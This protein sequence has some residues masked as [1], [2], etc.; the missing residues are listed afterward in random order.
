MFSDGDRQVV[1]TYYTQNYRNGCPPGLVR[2]GNDCLTRGMARRQYAV[3]RRLARNVVIAPV[4]A[5][6]FRQLSPVP[7]GYRYGL[8]D[9]DV[10][11]YD[12][13]TRLVV[14]AI[15]ALLD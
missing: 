8:V 3:G 5:P 7:S 11:R 2:R 10:I 13:T 6:L 14:D 9:G 4:P 1:R 15:R 12:S